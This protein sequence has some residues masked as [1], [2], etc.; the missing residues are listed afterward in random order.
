MSS[1]SDM[2]RA[3]ELLNQFSIPYGIVVNKYDI[4]LDVYNRI[5]EFAKDKF[6]GKI[7]YNKDIVKELVK[8]NPVI[9]SNL[10]IVKELEQVYISLKKKI[11]YSFRMLLLV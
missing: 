2:K 8:I 1:E 3:I 6:L 10:K 5:K 11:Q 4:N 7:S 9:E